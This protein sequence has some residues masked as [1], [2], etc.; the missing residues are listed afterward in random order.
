MW[1]VLGGEY[2]KGYEEILQEVREDDGAHIAFEIADDEAVNNAERGKRQDGAEPS[3][4][5]TQPKRMP[6]AKMA[7]MGE[8]SQAVNCCRR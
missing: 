7:A 1:N 6:V 5:W 2:E 8:R 4:R 3:Y